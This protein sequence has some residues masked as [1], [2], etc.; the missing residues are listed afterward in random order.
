MP[1]IHVITD[2][3]C[4]M[5]PQMAEERGVR[6]VPLTIRF[7][8]EE[9]IDREELS[10]KEFWDRV[11]TGTAMPETAA[12]SPGAFQAAY[13]A[14]AEAGA[15]AVACITLSSGVSATYQS[16]CTAAESVADRIK[17]SVT[18]SQSVTMGQGL[19]VLTAT[20][21]AAEGASLENIDTEVRRRRDR[22]RVYGVVDSLDFLKRGGRIGGAAHLMGSLLSIKPVIEIRNGVVEVESKQRTRARSLQYLA[23]KALE[24]GPIDRI[25]VA[26]GVAPDI[27]EVLSALAGVHPAHELVVSDLGP[28]V[29]AH[30]GPGTIG[31]CF[32]LAG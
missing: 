19:L 21:M 31:L 15:D 2:S 24:A 29:G 7:G 4:D 12:P 5:T 16:A 8:D 32:Q 9:F 17:V 23:S 18:D 1:G 22:S 3:A 13:L 6:V 11:T 30:G 20:D 28:V 14:A 25:A 10:T 27:D 26:N